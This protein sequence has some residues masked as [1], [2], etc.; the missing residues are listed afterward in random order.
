MKRIFSITITLLLCFS[1]VGA[2]L[3]LPQV[4]NDSYAYAAESSDG[5]T[6]QKIDGVKASITAQG[7]MTISWGPIAFADGYQV[8]KSTRRDGGYKRI[9]IQ[10]SDSS[11][12]CYDDK[13]TLG[14][15]YYYKVR[16]YR[17]VNGVKQYTQYSSAASRRMTAGPLNI[18]N[19][20]ITVAGKATV[21]VSFLYDGDGYQ[22]YS[23]DLSTNKKV[24]LKTVKNNQQQRVSF[25]LK[26]PKDSVTFVARNYIIK[27][28]KKYYGDYGDYFTV[29]VNGNE[30]VKIGNKKLRN[31]VKKAVG[32]GKITKNKL[33]KIWSIESKAPYEDWEL[34]DCSKNDFSFLKYCNGLG[35]LGLSYCELKDASYIFDNLPRANRIRELD[36]SSNQIKNVAGIEKLKKLETVNLESNMLTTI[37]GIEK[38]D[39][40]TELNIG[41]NHITDFSAIRDLKHRIVLYYYAHNG[42]MPWNQE[43]LGESTNCREFVAICKEKYIEDVYAEYNENEA[44]GEDLLDSIISK[45]IS[46]N[47]TDYQK[48]KAIH[49]YI[50]NNFT[51]GGYPSMSLVPLYYPAL[52]YNRGVCA[53]YAFA[54]DALLGRVGIKSFYIT[55]DYGEGHAWNIVQLDGQYY[56]VDCTWDD[57]I[58]GSLRYMYFL[59]S[60]AQMNVNRYYPWETSKYPACPNNYS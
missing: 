52:Y 27:N 17:T 34:G 30:E 25:T 3:N 55:S 9:A 33:A 26:N 18:F 41:D 28:G 16:A 6:S 56:H 23:H 7:N 5:F 51:Y 58:G 40:L 31:I 20:K 8:Y 10:K 60:D 36:F 4:N 11:M 37:D 49:D 29:F 57:P 44:K 13:T 12:Y 47:M 39:N 50:V 35:T 45:I 24:L 46:D 2:A 32:G 48:I 1:L 59:I 21:E 14:K 54:N 43:L 22:I 19:A 38:L 42:A 15:M 53:D